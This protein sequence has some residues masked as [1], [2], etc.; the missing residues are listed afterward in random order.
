MPELLLMRSAW[1]LLQTALTQARA[2]H[3]DECCHL[4]GEIEARKVENASIAAKAEENLALKEKEW[5][6]AMVALQQEQREHEERS[7]QVEAAL[8]QRSDSQALPESAALAKLGLLTL[9][10]SA[11]LHEADASKQ[12]ADEI[13]CL[14]RDREMLCEQIRDLQERIRS[15]QQDPGK[16]PQRCT[17][18]DNGLFSSCSFSRPCSCPCSSPRSCHCSRPWCLRS[19]SNAASGASAGG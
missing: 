5:L 19:C 13:L 7:T 1:F 16:R 14:H 12:Q 8:R 10:N 15:L 9:R 6:Q 11:D 18:K 2:Q 17:G 3:A 4:Q